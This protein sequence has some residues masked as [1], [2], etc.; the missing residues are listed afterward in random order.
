MHDPSKR[1][2][3]STREIAQTHLGNGDVDWNPE[4]TEKEAF[5][6]CSWQTISSWNRV[7]R[8]GKR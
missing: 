7:V 2:K 4:T 3:T 6:N 1:P 8:A 5:W